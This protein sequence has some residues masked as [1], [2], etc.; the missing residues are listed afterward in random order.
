MFR[1]YIGDTIHTHTRHKPNK[2]LDTLDKYH[3][4]PATSF[5]PFGD[6]KHPRVSIYMKMLQYKP[7]DFYFVVVRLKPKNKKFKWAVLS[8]TNQMSSDVWNGQFVKY[9]WILRDPTTKR[10]R[11]FASPANAIIAA[12]KEYKRRAK[13][14]K[15]LAKR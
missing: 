15:T 1:D 8:M 5:R 3:W 9:S 13:V 11:M 14:K 10:R 2:H 4:R 7:D 12:E 6:S